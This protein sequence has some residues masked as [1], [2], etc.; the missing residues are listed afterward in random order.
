M[1][2]S[3]IKHQSMSDVIC[4]KCDQR[5]AREDAARCTGGCG[6]WYCANNSAGGCKGGLSACY[7]CSRDCCDNCMRGCE[8][9]RNDRCRQCLD[10]QD[11]SRRKFLVCERHERR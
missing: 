11:S 6:D 7:N 9:C 10:Y 5:V 3:V 1:S 4:G 2:G 8:F